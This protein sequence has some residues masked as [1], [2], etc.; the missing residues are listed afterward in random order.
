[1][2]FPDAKLFLDS[3]PSSHSCTY[4]VDVLPR[5]F[6][7]FSRLPGWAVA[8]LPFRGGIPGCFSDL[9]Y[10]VTR[11][12]LQTKN[13]FTSS[14]KP[15]SRRSSW[16]SVPPFRLRLAETNA[17]RIA[18]AIH[19]HDIGDVNG[20]FLLGDT[21]LDVAW[22]FGLTCFLTMP[23]PSTRTRSFSAMMR[24]TR[25]FLPLSLAGDDV[26]VSLRLNLMLPYSSCPRR[27]G[28]AGPES[29]IVGFFTGKAHVIR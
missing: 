10:C 17:G 21:A 14:C 12:R 6:F 9:L 2:T 18:V 11:L 23:T 29:G 5:L 27:T 7:S 26:T 20:G 19:Q 3:P 13:S 25:P 4:L 15:S 8:R 28:A 16:R 1:M 22:G 24:R